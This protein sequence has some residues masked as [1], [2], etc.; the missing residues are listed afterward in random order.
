[1]ERE[2]TEQELVRREKAEKI[3]ELGMDP[4]VMYLKEQIGL[5]IL[6]LNLLILIMKNLKIEMI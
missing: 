6:K 5:V 3:R 2:F 1:M 4:L